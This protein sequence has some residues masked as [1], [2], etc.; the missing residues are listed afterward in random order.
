MNSTPT[1]AQSDEAPVD[2]RGLLDDWDRQQSG[3]LGDREK[4][5]RVALDAIEVL[6][7]DAREDFVVV[8]LA[9]GPGSFS[10]RLLARFPAARVIAV[11]MDPVLLRV[12]RGA[13]GA[14]DGRL[15]WVEVDLRDPSWV[16]ELGV[17]QV[18][19]VVSSTALHWL[20]PHQL[21]AT[22]QR[23]AG[24]VRRGGLF[25]NAD[26]MSYDPGQ[27]AMATL[28][29]AAQRRRGNEVSEQG[30]TPDWDA[31][32]SGLA[33]VADLDAAR[34]ERTRRAEDRRPGEDDHDPGSRLTGVRL[35]VAALVE[36][37]FVEVDTIWQDHDDR[38]L[39]AVR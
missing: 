20:S 23:L 34:A 2:W 9:C 28:S 17:T 7:A 38:V 37:G 14:A 4:R 33:A 27:A 3:Y 1:T 8:D 12:G 25:I 29:S 6:R 21:A 19:A 5:F 35:H 39:L 32:W 22:Y 30:D 13:L 36:A 11:D 15:T 26:N 24:L 10:E 16:G 18:D 31:W